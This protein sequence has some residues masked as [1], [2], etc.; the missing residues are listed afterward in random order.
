MMASADAANIRPPASGPPPR[1]RGTY[2]VDALSP[3]RGAGTSGL[4]ASQMIII[5]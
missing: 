2:K 1:G 5:S 4:P 3:L